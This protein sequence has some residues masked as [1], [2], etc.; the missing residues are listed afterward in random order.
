MACLWTS[1]SLLIC[2]IVSL[3]PRRCPIG[4]FEEYRPQFPSVTQEDWIW[5]GLTVLWERWF[6]DRPN[7]EM[8]DDGMQA[9]Y[10][11]MEKGQSKAACEA[12]VKVWRDV[13]RLADKF[14][15]SSIATF[16]KRFKGTQCVFNWC[17]DLEQELWNEGLDDE[18]L[19][20]ERI[21]LCEDLLQMIKK[22]D[23]LTRENSRRAIA[24]SHFHLGDKD[25]ADGLF[26]EWLKDDPTWGWGWIGWSTCYELRATPHHSL[27]RAHEIYME[28][29]AVPRLRDRDD[30]VDRLQCLCEDMG[31]PVPPVVAEFIV[32]PA[33][34]TH[35]IMTKKVGRNEPCP[36][37]S[38][39]KF[40]KC[41]GG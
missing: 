18:G 10:E 21:S 34:V 37:G 24:Q 8:I 23:D 30:L 39:K 22:D 26:R 13:K 16:D 19:M 6:P 31:R 33:P 36:C 11:L 14:D 20:L 7:F 38:G 5:I 27:E 41:C 2:A 17:Q 1:H 32:K 3:P 35:P 25:R 4:P 12:W 40:K 9:G 29:L 28:G 15:L